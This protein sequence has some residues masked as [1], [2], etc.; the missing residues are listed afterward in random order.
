MT[1]IDSSEAPL[2][3]TGIAVRKE[4]RVLFLLLPEVQLLDL[5]GPAQ[6]F[7][8]ATELGMPCKLVFC[9]SHTQVRSAQGL[10]FAQL[11]P[12]VSVTSDDLVMVPGLQLSH[13]FSKVFQLNP[14]EHKWLSQAYKEGAYIASICTGAFALAQAGLLDARRCTTHWMSVDD[15]RENYPRA[16]VVEDVLFVQ[17][18]RI[19]TSAGI[20]SG[21]DMALALLEQRFGP[22]FTA[23]VARYLVIYL[24]RNGSHSQNS[25]YLQYRTHLNPAVHRAQDYLIAHMNEAVALEKLAGIAAVSTRSL[26]RIFKE[27]TGITPVQYHQ[28]LQLELASSLLSDPDLSIEEI[29]RRCGFEDA[30]HFRRLWQRQFGSPPSVSRASYQLPEK[31]QKMRQQEHS[32]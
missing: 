4:Q 13:D 9:A 17:D 14:Q 19:T 26:S 10:A 30:R 6:V 23:E 7:A 5:A 28:R 18:G 32:A 1:R 25:V 12:L 8:A 22:L 11:E 3:Y 29:A 24:R 21:I 16:H 20:A 31:Q 15:L 27:A 2:E